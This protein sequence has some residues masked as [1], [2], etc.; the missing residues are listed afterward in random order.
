MKTWDSEWVPD[1]NKKTLGQS[2]TMLA[3]ETRHWLQAFEF[4]AEHL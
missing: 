1:R 3:D 4:G 2:A